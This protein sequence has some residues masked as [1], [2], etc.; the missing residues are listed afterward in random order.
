MALLHHLPGIDGD[1]VFPGFIHTIYHQ[2]LEGEKKFR[3][4][5]P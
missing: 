1:R 2:G 5:E 3:S 4:R